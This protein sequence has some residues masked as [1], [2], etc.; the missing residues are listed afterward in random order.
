MNSVGFVIALP[1]EARTLVRRRIRFNEL[2]ELPGGHRLIV[3]GAGPTH[4]YNAAARLLEHK[5]GALVSWGCAA[6]LAPT[7]NAGDLVLPR[8]ILAPDGSRHAVCPEWHERVRKTLAP[9]TRV[10]T[11]PL[12]GNFEIVANAA[13]K[14]KLHSTKGAVAVDMESAAVASVA[15]AQGL[16]FLAVRAIADS[17]DMNLPNAVTV[18]VDNRGDINLT[19]LLGYALAHPAEFATLA[20]LGKAFHAAVNTLRRAARRLGTDLFLTPSADG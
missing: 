18:A 1:A 19:K 13:E 8:Q 14:Q 10:L 16:P 12:L 4:A 5:V 7:L 9:A 15:T 11:G 2:V 3:S 20:R 17:A 6:A